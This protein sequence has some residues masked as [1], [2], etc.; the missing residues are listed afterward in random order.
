MGFSPD[1]I[2]R[3]KQLRINNSDRVLSYARE[4]V[5]MLFNYYRHSTADNQFLSNLR[6]HCKISMYYP[7]N[8]NISPKI[9]RIVGLYA[10]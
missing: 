1:F 2:Q 8:T 10:D 9:E 7:S 5:W 6:K 3:M 4:L